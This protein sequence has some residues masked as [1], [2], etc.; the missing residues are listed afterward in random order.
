VY[1][2]SVVN[3]GATAKCRSS[4]ALAATE[5]RYVLHSAGGG[6]SNSAAASTAGSSRF[7]YCN[8]PLFNIRGP[9]WTGTTYNMYVV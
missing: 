7:F 9:W 6:R 4:L 5:M 2:E 8:L 3:K 1:H